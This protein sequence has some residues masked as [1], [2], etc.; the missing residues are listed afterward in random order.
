M[1][2]R[3]NAKPDTVFPS[4]CVIEYIQHSR[5]KN[6]SE[7]ALNEK[8]AEWNKILDGMQNK[9]LF[10]DILM[11]IQP[12]GKV[13]GHF[14]EGKLNF[15]WAIGWASIEAR[16]NAWDEWMEVGDPKWQKSID[17]IFNYDNNTVIFRPT[18]GRQPS[19]QPRSSEAIIEF[20]HCTFR[21]GKGHK[22]LMAY[23]DAFKSLVDAYEEQ[24]GE[25]SYF[26]YLLDFAGEMAPEV[27]E[28]P[29]KKNWSGYI[30]INVWSSM[31]AREKSIAYYSTSDLASQAGSISSCAGNIA[32]TKRIRTES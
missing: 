18:V 23:W 13:F 11:P 7:E 2:S 26:Y 30:W 14:A 16:N 15:T 6:F 4:D 10:S 3:K 24:N 27:A 25:T 29:E 21:V 19:I 8:I 28:E 22:D 17:G 31:E 32:N 1:K 5:G 20:N 9:I 12:E